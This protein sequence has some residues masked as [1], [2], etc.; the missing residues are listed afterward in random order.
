[1]KVR[2]CVPCENHGFIKIWQAIAEIQQYSSTGNKLS[3]KG[4]SEPP[5]HQVIVRNINYFSA[6]GKCFLRNVWLRRIMP[7]LAH[8]AAFYSAPLISLLF[9]KNIYQISFIYKAQHMQA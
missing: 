6:S 9:K 1:M 2:V 8:L 7:T 5:G 4:L 3:R